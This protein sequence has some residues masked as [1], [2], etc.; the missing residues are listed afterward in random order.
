M[1]GPHK[2][3]GNSI[4]AFTNLSLQKEEELQNQIEELESKVAEF[5]QSSA[6][7]NVSLC[8]KFHYIFLPS[9]LIL[10]LV[11]LHFYLQW[12]ASST[13]Y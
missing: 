3:Q 1:I 8:L 7:Q 12:T 5:N 2:V 6:M 10:K 4:G 9:N 11:S 13:G